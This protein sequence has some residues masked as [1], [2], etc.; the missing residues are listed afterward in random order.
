MPKKR[1]YSGVIDPIT[2][3][4]VLFLIITAGIGTYVVR[5]RD[6]NL[7]INERASCTNTCLQSDF[8]EL[9]GCTSSNIDDAPAGSGGISVQDEIDEYEEEQQQQNNTPV[10]QPTTP[11]TTGCNANGTIYQNGAIVVGGSS[12]SGYSRC[13]GNAWVPCPTCTI[14]QLTTVPAYLQEQ[15]NQAVQDILTEQEIAEQTAPRPNDL[16]IQLSDNQQEQ[17]DICLL[18]GGMWSN[19]SMNCTY[20]APQLLQEQVQTIQNSRPRGESRCSGSTAEVWDG[21]TWDGQYCANGCINGSCI[22]EIKESIQVNRDDS[23]TTRDLTTFIYSNDQIVAANIYSLNMYNNV[24]KVDDGFI[25]NFTTVLRDKNTDNIFSALT[26]SVHSQPQQPDQPIYNFGYC[27]KEGA[28]AAEIAECNQT[29]TGIYNAPLIGRYIQ[30]YANQDIA[31]NYVQMGYDSVSLCVEGE[32]T[33]TGKQRCN[34]YQ[35]TK[36]QSSSSVALGSA[37]TAGGAVVVAGGGLATGA[38]TLLTAGGSQALLAAGVTTLSQSIALGMA[39]MSTYQLGTTTDICITEGY[40]DNCRTQIAWTALSYAN[41]GSSAL[42]SAYQTSRVISG[43]N[44]IINTVNVLTDVADISQSCGD[45]EYAS[46]FGCGAAIVGTIFDV[47]Q[48]VSDFGIIE[49]IAKNINFS[50]V[51]NNPLAQVDFQSSSQLQLG[52]P[53]TNIPKSINPN[54]V[55]DVVQGPNNIFVVPNT[56]TTALAVAPHLD[57]AQADGVI[58][59]T[60]LDEIPAT[61]PNSP[62]VIAGLLMAPGQPI[63]VTREF[64]DL[65]PKVEVDPNN[66][67]TSFWNEAVESGKKVLAGLL[68]PQERGSLGIPSPF[69]NADNSPTID[70]VVKRVD[71]ALTRSGEPNGVGCRNT[72][73]ETSAGFVKADAEISGL[74]ANNYDLI[75]VLNKMGIPTESISLNRNNHVITVVVDKNGKRYLSDLT[76]GQFDNIDLNSPIAKQLLK[77][78]YFEMTDS[79]LNEYLKLFIKIDF[80]KISVNIFD[81]INPHPILS[82]DMLDQYFSGKAI[83]LREI[84]PLEA[85]S[86]K[87]VDDILS[88]TEILIEKGYTYDQIDEMFFFDQINASPPE[89]STI[90][91]NAPDLKV[92]TTTPLAQRLGDWAGQI[93]DPIAS[94]LGLNIIF[95]NLPFID[96]S[97]IA[98]LPGGYPTVKIPSDKGL[99]ILDSV[100]IPENNRHIRG[101][102]MKDGTFVLTYDPNKDHT[103]LWNEY[104]LNSTYA[105]ASFDANL[106]QIDSKFNINEIVPEMARRMLEGGISGDLKFD[107]SGKYT[108]LGLGRYEDTV[109]N[110]A[111]GLDQTKFKPFSLYNTNKETFIN[112]LG[113]KFEIG[114]GDRLRS[115]ESGKYLI[116]YISDNRVDLK[117]ETGRIEQISLDQFRN[118]L[119]ETEF[120]VYRMVGKPIYILP[121]G[122]YPIKRL[123]NNKAPFAGVIDI[124]GRISISD[125]TLSHNTIQDN[126]LLTDSETTGRITYDP[127]KNRDT[128]IISGSQDAVNRIVDQINAIQN[129]PSWYDSSIFQRF[130]KVKIYIFTEYGRIDIDTRLHQ[131]LNRVR[132]EVQ[133]Q[134]QNSVKNPQI[135]TGTDPEIKT[136]INQQANNIIPNADTENLGNS[137]IITDRYGKS[138]WARD[139]IQSD[140]TPEFNQH[141]N[142]LEYS[143]RYYSPDE[144]KGIIDFYGHKKGAMD[145]PDPIPVISG[146]SVGKGETRN[147]I[148]IT[149]HEKGIS[150][151]MYEYDRS[152]W[153]GAELQLEPIAKGIEIPI[154]SIEGDAYRYLPIENDLSV[155]PDELKKKYKIIEFISP[156]VDI[157]NPFDWIGRIARSVEKAQWK[158][159]GADVGELHHAN[160]VFVVWDQKP[161]SDFTLPVIR[162]K[163]YII[164]D[165]KVFLP[166]ISWARV[167]TIEVRI[168]DGG[169][170]NSNYNS[171]IPILFGNPYR[172]SVSSGVWDGFKNWLQELDV[173]SVIDDIPW[174]PNSVKIALRGTQLVSNN[175]LDMPNIKTQTADILPYGMTQ[176][177]YDQLK[178]WASDTSNGPTAKKPEI[179]ENGVI[180]YPEQILPVQELAPLPGTPEYDAM[181]K[182]ALAREQSRGTDTVVKRGPSDTPLTIIVKRAAAAAPLISERVLFMIA[183][184]V[185]QTMTPSSTILPASAINDQV[186]VQTPNGTKID[187]TIDA[188][189]TVKKKEISSVT[190][191]ANQQIRIG[192]RRIKPDV[193]FTI[194]I[195]DIIVI[196]PNISLKWSGINDQFEIIVKEK[197]GFWSKILGLKKVT[198]ISRLDNQR[199]SFFYPSDQIVIESQLKEFPGT[200][201]KTIPPPTV[202][203]KKVFYSVTINREISYYPLGEINVL[204]Q[205][206]TNYFVKFGVMTEVDGKPDLTQLDDLV[207]GKNADGTFITLRQTGHQYV[208]S[209]TVNN[210]G[211]VEII[212]QYPNIFESLGQSV[213]NRLII[214]G[215]NNPLIRMYFYSPETGFFPAFNGFLEKIDLRNWIGSGGPAGDIVEQ[216]RPLDDLTPSQRLTSELKDRLN[217]SL[218][219]EIKA[220]FGENKNFPY[221]LQIKGKDNP[222]NPIDRLLAGVRDSSEFS[223]F[224][225]GPKSAK[226]KYVIVIRDIGTK[227]E[228]SGQGAGK[229]LLDAIEKSARE[230]G[231]D[232]IV[233]E[234]IFPYNDIYKQS[235]INSG[236]PIEN[237]AY[238]FWLKQGYQPAIDPNL[239]YTPTFS[240]ENPPH[241]MIKILP[242][243]ETSSPTRANPLSPSGVWDGVKNWWQRNVATPYNNYTKG[244]LELQ[245][246]NNE[247]R[248]SLFGG[249]AQYIEKYIKNSESGGIMAFIKKRNSVPIEDEQIAALEGRKT[250]KQENVIKVQNQQLADQAQKFLNSRTAKKIEV[251]EG[252]E[253]AQKRAKAARTQGMTSLQKSQPTESTTLW[254]WFFGGK[255]KNSG[256]T[257]VE[258]STILPAVFAVPTVGLYYVD[259]YFDLG[260]TD[261]FLNRIEQELSGDSKSES[262]NLPYLIWKYTHDRFLGVQVGSKFLFSET[263]SNPTIKT[264]EPARVE[265]GGK[266]NSNSC[267]LLGD[268]FLNKSDCESNF[269]FGSNLCDHP[270]YNNEQRYCCPIGKYHSQKSILGIVNI[271]ICADDNPR[272]LYEC[273]TT[274]SGICSTNSSD[275]FGSANCWSSINHMEV[276]CCASNELNPDGS[277]K[278]I[279]PRPNNWQD[280]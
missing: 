167:E 84:E 270:Y 23:G 275:H 114:P 51:A 169:A 91:R 115:D 57:I 110:L 52:A 137:F 269:A 164:G 140:I 257:L 104:G 54:N 264:F 190:L 192:W 171:I 215:S 109:E 129:D 25:R 177:E 38:Y 93:L 201:I 271:P 60:I 102:F 175:G 64:A 247:N 100:S 250:A 80:E 3:I 127:D 24:E 187:P 88:A 197:P 49:A 234:D 206:K 141:L 37:M 146:K 132:T 168:N 95:E 145:G 219:P 12:S 150:W 149:D 170:I 47:G 236:A 263:T 176:Q 199:P 67:P 249:L 134:K 20:T 154:D 204:P 267:E 174:I 92:N 242:D 72:L 123:L 238:S 78:G 31:Y 205:S 11:P 212:H 118:K 193:E 142:E 224:E 2:I 243:S 156:I 172:P 274:F 83:N 280:I 35:P 245:R 86:V 230:M 262:I 209:M 163:P 122:A 73:C 121:G 108:G 232:T 186:K 14:T 226:S 251:Q 214:V 7:D 229:I 65:K 10:I 116:V 119:D 75:Q 56:S 151:I 46:G 126:Q 153:D 136:N 222:R 44:T 53:D 157:V 195:N 76:I 96:N 162:L 196:S 58:T 81:S 265:S 45:D 74:D 178:T 240:P 180:Q 63:N 235:N 39:G 244:S 203:G 211:N 62:Q 69:R 198:P 4:G 225:I 66:A 33:Y 148:L 17:K 159:L 103:V 101:Y 144:N 32:E 59:A 13:D 256:Q 173:I 217:K 6:I 30:S 113:D 97:N 106:V 216:I 218:P 273:S 258:F 131:A 254:T 183:E 42:Q 19:Q 248:T 21:S 266:S 239:G 111:K 98:K 61:P 260:I 221:E 82:A 182:K 99:T 107:I 233:A 130:H 188:V 255:N 34:G 228:A 166:G 155:F 259:Q 185:V 272:N 152:A 94:R 36:E 237:S 120:S 200:T 128:I 85:S 105:I 253:S 194:D 143:V 18:D 89:Y 147:A 223:Q 50:N 9:C 179:N 277:C 48:S 5:N 202:K 278:D 252:F 117:Y 135:K 43:A 71:E 124:N 8:P 191:T 165:N 276:W 208:T 161:K 133:I 22:T 68:N 160:V 79:N 55:I 227:P 77:D 279:L 27:N 112:K 220:A 268:N 246:Q 87:T 16:A 213:L 139:I 261:S 40:T 207:V 231:I 138:I 15:Y 158:N 184:D 29:W 70:A 26:Q 189:L 41:I 181:V 210:S 241:S 125:E 1:L 28:S 90:A